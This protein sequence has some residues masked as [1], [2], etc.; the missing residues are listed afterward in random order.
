MTFRSG[1]EGG[2]VWQGLATFYHKVDKKLPDPCQ[3]CQT[4][5]TVWQ[6]FL[7]C[8]IALLP[9]LPLLPC[10]HLSLMR[11]S[12]N[13]RFRSFSLHLRPLYGECRQQWQPRQQGQC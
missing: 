7:L 11:C 3:C 1:T 5:A 10:L 4:P 2:K 13:K 8:K 12:K 6:R 9:G